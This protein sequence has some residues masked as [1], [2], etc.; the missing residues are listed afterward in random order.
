M[1]L[2]IY[3]FFVKAVSIKNIL[4]ASSFRRHLLLTE[5]IHCKTGGGAGLFT[6]V[7]F[8]KSWFM[9]RCIITVPP[10]GTMNT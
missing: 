5:R 2:K 4:S 7:K 9:K 8:Q 1:L 3:H 6:H 10:H